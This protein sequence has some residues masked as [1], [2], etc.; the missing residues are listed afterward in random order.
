MIKVA[1]NIKVHVKSSSMFNKGILFVCCINQ[2]DVNF[3]RLTN[4]ICI[5][6]LTERYFHFSLRMFSET[7]LCKSAS[8]NNPGT[9]VSD[10][11]KIGFLFRLRDGFLLLKD[12]PSTT[13]TDMR[14][15]YCQRPLS[16]F[17]CLCFRSERR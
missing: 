13:D 6:T 3:F 17:N 1:G 10:L 9:L 8:N 4:L 11:I 14:F 16:Y 12:F 5:Q 2:S 7:K 15:A